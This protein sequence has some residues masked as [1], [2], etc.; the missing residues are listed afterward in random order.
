MHR[1]FVN[2]GLRAVNVGL[3]AI[4]NVVNVGL[5]ALVN[6]GLHAVIFLQVLESSLYRGG[7]T[8]IFNL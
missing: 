4:V 2:V 7:S 6:V 1:P 8:E 3:H 5:R